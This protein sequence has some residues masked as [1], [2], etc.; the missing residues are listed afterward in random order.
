[1][2]EQNQKKGGEIM[3]KTKKYFF[4]LGVLVA[5]LLPAL[6]ANAE[7]MK[8][9]GKMTGLTCLTQGYICPL[10]KADPMINLEK[11]FVLVTASGDYYFLSN[12]TLGLK[13]RHALE[14]L[15]V[16]GDVNAK[17]KSMKVNKI[18]KDGKVI[19]TQQDEDKMM[20]DIFKKGVS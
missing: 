18:S 19:W 14:V 11:D 15:D 12:I 2:A 8:L 4:F 9:T 20:E 10:D 3:T 7:M 13:A 1:L 17:Y 6:V 16:T 5:L